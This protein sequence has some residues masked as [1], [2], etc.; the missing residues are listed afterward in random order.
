MN[1]S[2]KHALRQVFRTLPFIAL[3]FAMIASE[4]RAADATVAIEKVRA[5][6]DGDVFTAEISTT[7][8]WNGTDVQVKYMNDFIQAE[9]AGTFLNN[10]KRACSR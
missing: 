9:V 4:A 1:K 5:F 3:F 2:F 6:R 8:A 10:G 7:T